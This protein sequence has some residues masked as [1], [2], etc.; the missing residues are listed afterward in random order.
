MARCSA[1]L[2]RAPCL[3]TAPR[4]LKV[5]HLPGGLSVVSVSF[6][7]DISVRLAVLDIIL[8]F[9][10]CCPKMQA[11]LSRIDRVI[12]NYLPGIRMKVLLLTVS[13]L[14]HWG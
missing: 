3:V 7:D 9:S 5:Q 6:K 11:L 13:V 1:V 14:G 2:C 10:E 12:K 8:L 4:C